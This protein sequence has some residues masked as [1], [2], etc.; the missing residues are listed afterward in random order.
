MAEF[1]IETFTKPVVD[2]WTKTTSTI[3]SKFGKKA[4]VEMIEEKAEEVKKGCLS[5]CGKK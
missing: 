4:P 5:C 1:K 3:S 2:T